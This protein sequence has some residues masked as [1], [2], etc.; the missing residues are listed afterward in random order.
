[1]KLFALI[2]LF[3][4][5]SVNAFYSISYAS[6]KSQLYGGIESFS[7]APSA[8]TVADIYTRMSG[9]PPL[10]RE[11]KLNL[12]T[13][14]VFSKNTKL[15]T[16][17]EVHGGRLPVSVTNI[18]KSTSFS[19]NVNGPVVENVVSILKEHGITT[20]SVKIKDT[21][22]GLSISE[23]VENYLKTQDGPVVILHHENPIDV[24]NYARK[25]TTNGTD[26]EPLTE[27]QISEYQI[28]MW[29]GIVFI[30]LCYSAVQGVVNMEVIP[31]S[32]LY[33]KFM[34]SR[35]HRND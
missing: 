33:A 35:T 25:L 27:F 22:D 18:V 16:I 23:K 3:A 20:E 11:D 5:S 19:N 1:M 2:L 14:D 29:S 13:T 7:E 9:I 26:V 24:Y 17:L 30:L 15:P 12:I 28:C 8:E 21:T 6:E 34:S 10:Y 4:I 31:D 32:L